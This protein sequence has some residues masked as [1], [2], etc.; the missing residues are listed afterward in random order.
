MDTNSNPM[1]TEQ[2]SGELEEEL[3]GVL[4]AISIVSR[5]LAR[6]L[7]ALS[8]QEALSKEGDKGH[9]QNERTQPSD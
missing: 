8:K 1:D 6:K 4:I 9:G 7:A 2:R 5:R 3:A